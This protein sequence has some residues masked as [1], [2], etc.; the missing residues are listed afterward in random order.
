M[1]KYV[2][3]VCVKLATRIVNCKTNKLIC[4]VI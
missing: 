1:F 3:L 2:A 4:F